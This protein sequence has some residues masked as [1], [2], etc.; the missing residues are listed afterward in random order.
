ML[1]HDLI[2]AL[3]KT[4]K[5]PKAD[6]QARHTFIEKML[7]YQTNNHPLVYSDESGFALDM[8]REC[9]YSQRGQRCYGQKDWHAKGRLNAIG[10]V[11]EMELITV[12]LFD[13]HINADIFYAWLTQ[14]LLPKLPDKSVLIMDNARFHK[15]E[16][17]LEAISTKGF[18]L[19]FLP[20]Y[21]PD[22]NPIEH[23]WAEV[24]AARR[25]E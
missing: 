17:I 24:K 3:K 20:A 11:I 23:K 8:P 19:E 13:S 1:Y 16:D 9:G 21:S 18:L 12:S 15:R 6:E 5:H 14:D 10:A 25:R 2:L 7:A 4:L 22:L